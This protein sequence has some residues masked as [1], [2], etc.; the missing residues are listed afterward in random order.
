[1]NNIITTT[2]Q[3]TSL[4]ICLM[5][6]VST[7]SFGQQTDNWY[8]GS[9]A[10]FANTGLRVSFTTGSPVVTTGYPLMTEEG[11]SSISDASGN[12]LFYTDGVSVWDGVTN[13]TIP[14]GTGLNGGSSTT[15]SAII[16]PMPGSTTQ[17]LLFTS[18]TLSNPGT[19]YY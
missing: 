7:L 9:A 10:G 3:K 18:G 14:G 4:F 11:S 6:L 13:A 1:M 15:Q 12:I 8:F 19:Y 17:W 16:M 2:A 5:L